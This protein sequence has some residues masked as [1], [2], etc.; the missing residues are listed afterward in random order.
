MNHNLLSLYIILC[1]S[2]SMFL[3]LSSIR[4][5][6]ITSLQYIEREHVTVSDKAVCVPACRSLHSTTDVGGR[7]KSVSLW[8]TLRP[9][10]SPVSDQKLNFFVNYNN[11]K[12]Y[13]FTFKNSFIHLLFALLRYSALTRD[14]IDSLIRNYK[15]GTIE[16]TEFTET[17]VWS[18]IIYI[19]G[20]KLD[21]LY[22]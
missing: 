7:R 3:Y 15:D 14:S 2:I 20:L 4:L 22:K 13:L 19:S 5:T 21:Y 1:T 12:R 10:K 11:W 17:E 8:Q 18:W 16:F 9:Y 6:F